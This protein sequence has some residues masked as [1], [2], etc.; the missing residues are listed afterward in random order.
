MTRTYLYVLSIAAIFSKSFDLWWNE[1][2]D[3]EPAHM[4]DGSCHT[5]F[6]CSV[7]HIKAYTKFCSKLPISKP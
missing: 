3:I 6:F 4:E 1:S 7:V 2:I 5:V